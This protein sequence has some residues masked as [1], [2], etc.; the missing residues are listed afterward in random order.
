MRA[1]MNAG[2]S[3]DA[4]RALT[5]LIG[6][7]DVAREWLKPPER[8]STGLHFIKRS[9]PASLLLADLPR[10]A[11][12]ETHTCWITAVVTSRTNKRREIKITG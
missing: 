6:K 8:V 7:A 12:N 11:T 3:D 1:E 5:E 2:N 9:R 10:N 4:V